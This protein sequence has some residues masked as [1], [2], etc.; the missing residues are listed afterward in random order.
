MNFLTGRYVATAYNN[1]RAGEWPPHPARLFSA[2]VDAWAD[3]DEREPY[4]SRLLEWLEEQG[5]PAIAASGAEHRRVVSHF[6]PV[7][8]ATVVGT[9]L[10][11]RRYRQIQQLES[12][13]GQTIASSGEQSR[14]AQSIRTRLMKSRNVESQVTKAGTTNPSTALAMFPEQRVRQERFFPSVS[15]VVPKVTY[16]WDAVLS[17]EMRKALDDLLARVTRLGHSSSLVA[18]RLADYLPEAT[19][20]PGSAN[21]T[22][23]RTVQP[24]QFKELERLFERHGGNGPRSLPFTV[25]SYGLGDDSPKEPVQFQRPNTAGEWLVF[26]LEH[27]SRWLPVTRA[28]ELASAMRDAVIQHAVTPIPVEIS[29]I[30][31]DGKPVDVPHL[32]FLSLPFVGPRHAD[33][34]V[35]GVALSIPDGVSEAGRQVIYRA[36]GTWERDSADRRPT[37]R[38]ADGSV[39]VRL[40]RLLATAEAR[41]LQSQVW[42]REAL[43]WVSVSPIALP[44]HPGRLSEGTAAARAKA[45]QS[46][47]EAVVVSC[48]HVGLPAPVSIHLSLSP[49]IRGARHV[50][51]C[52]P[53][54]RKGKQGEVVRRQLVHAALTF[55]EPIR[56]P[57]MLGAGRFAGLG[58]MRP[59]SEPERPTEGES[60]E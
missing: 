13:L 39:K 9:A 60:H 22:N 30:G 8:D 44:K 14:K 37:L 3:R 7:N 47:E 57:L 42:S 28:P 33:G 25:T 56:G 19:L 26:E 46:A 53:F 29:G 16:L 48:E 59:I 11:E 55:D 20:L 5:P 1:R 27:G 17:D 40:T 24:G 45:W 2:M 49:L 12:E 58:L 32:A 31:S 51:D 54:Q 21:G 52:P 15:P 38:L 34:R 50:R 23:L 41:T 6:V 43:R 4:E 36:V 10:Q 18:C 35:M